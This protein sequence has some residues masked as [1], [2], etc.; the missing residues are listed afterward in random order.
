MSAHGTSGCHLVWR[1]KAFADRIK[2][3]EIRSSWIIQAGTKSNSK[4]PHGREAEEDL[5]HREG[6]HRDWTDAATKQELPKPPES[7]RRKDRVFLWDFG[8]VVSLL[9]L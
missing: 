8:G 6:R 3:L 5:R 9:A 4:G 7:G 1:R 2:D